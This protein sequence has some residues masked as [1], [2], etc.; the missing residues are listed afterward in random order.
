MYHSLMPELSRVPV[1]LG[2]KKQFLPQGYIVS[3][4]IH[5]VYLSC[6]Q[7]AVCCGMGMLCAGASFNSC[8]LYPPGLFW[9]LYLLSLQGYHSAVPLGHTLGTL[10]LQTGKPR[11]QDTQISG[12]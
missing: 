10:L 4:Y 7:K 9:V 6:L 3:Y 11:F 5:K 2:A 8:V 12:Q 1:L